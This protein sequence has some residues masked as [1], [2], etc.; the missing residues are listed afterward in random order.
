MRLLF[1]GTPTFAVPSLERLIE[2]G[3]RPV[4]VATAPDRKRGRGQRLTPTPVKEVALKHEIPV[5]QPESVKDPSFAEAV[6]ACRPDVIVVVAF[7]ILPP[8]VYTR[9]RLGAFNL[10]ASLLPAFRGAAPIQR[11]L[12]AG[13]TETGVTT[14]FLERKVD[15][16]QIILAKRIAVGPDETAGE[17]HD[18]LMHLGAEAVVETVRRIEL[19]AAST[20]E[21]DD[22]LATRAPKIFKDDARIPW[23]RDSRTVHDHVRGLSPVPGAWT[24]HGDVSLKL[25]RTRT[26]E[27]DGE[28]GSVLEADGRLVVACGSGAVE[29]LEIQQPGR[30]A[31]DA[32]AFLHGY[33]LKAGEQLV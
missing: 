15:T 3:Y 4:A 18:R 33:T 27:S 21:Q 20:Y 31:L 28:A 6:A 22:S 7:K 2:A 25:L 11:A 10:H 30:R 26:V 12:M 16:G 13:A 19:G 24:L 1:M 5:L 32:R 9:A 29:V 23:G 8:A 14:F 17:L